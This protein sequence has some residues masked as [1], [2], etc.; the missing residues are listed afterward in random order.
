MTGF[1]SVISIL[2][3]W[4]ILNDFGLLEQ[5]N[6]FL[7]LQLVVTGNSDVV[8]TDT[9]GEGESTRSKSYMFAKPK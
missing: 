6:T 3:F 1:G 8:L 9:V 7:R 5:T 4:Y 2:T